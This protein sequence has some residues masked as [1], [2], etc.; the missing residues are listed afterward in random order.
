MDELKEILKTDPA[1]LIIIDYEKLDSKKMDKIGCTKLYVIENFL[2]DEESGYLRS[3][4][5]KKFRETYVG[6]L[7]KRRIKKKVRNNKCYYIE[8]DF[9]N[10]ATIKRIKTKFSKLTNM[11]Y[12]NIEPL[13]IMK[14]EKNEFYKCHIDAWSD[15]Q[16]IEE[17]GNR[18]YSFF[19]YLNDLSPTDGGE[20]HFPVF[21]S[22]VAPTR[23][24]G[25]LW[26]NLLPNSTEANKLYYHQSL[27]IKTDVIKYGIL[28]LM[29]TQ[30]YK[31]FK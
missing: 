23:N 1:E 13:R 6:S 9:P 15:K 21:N 19:I 28:L 14:Y 25:A 4:D 3:F 8:D 7:G 10:N 11:P 16:V 30:P 22:K 31:K 5:N 2:T 26:N 20:T 18:Q 27:E 12:E 24:R 29:R 17:Y